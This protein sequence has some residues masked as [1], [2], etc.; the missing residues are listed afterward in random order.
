MATSL[1]DVKIQFVA[2]GV[3]NVLSAI[4]TLET[5]F[6]QL[7]N[8]MT[9]LAKKGAE[10]RTNAYR[11][12]FDVKKSLAE[13]FASDYNTILQKEVAHHHS[14]INRKEEQ[15]R[16]YTQVLRNEAA[17]RGQIFSAALQSMGIQGVNAHS[18]I[19]GQ[20]VPHG[21][22]S[23]MVGSAALLAGSAAFFGQGSI[24]RSRAGIYPLKDAFPAGMDMPEGLSRA[25]QEAFKIRHRSFGNIAKIGYHNFIAKPA[26]SVQDFLSSNPEASSPLSNMDRV[27]FSA[28]RAATGGWGRV[29]QQ[30]S[31][32]G[33]AVGSVMTAPI[34]GPVIAGVTAAL[35]AFKQ[36]LDVVTGA[37]KQAASEM[38]A[39]VM[40]I[41]GGFS[42]SGSLV[43]SASLQSM[44]TRISVNAATPAERMPTAEILDWAMSSSRTGEHSAEQYMSGMSTYQALT[45]RNK[46]FKNM[47][48]FIGKMATVSGSSF[49]E[50]AKSMGQTRLQFGEFSPQQMQ[51]LMLKQWQ[52]G[53]EGSIEIGNAG[54]MARVTAGARQLAG[55]PT[56]ENFMT[57]IGAVQ[58]ARRSVA[59]PEEAVTAYERFQSFAAANS[60]KIVAAGGHAV[61]TQTPEGEKF[62]DMAQTMVDAAK[63]LKQPGGFAKATSLYGREGIR[64]AQ[65][66]SN[67]IG[68][69][70][71]DEQALK[72]IRDL[73]KV[74]ASAEDLD[75]AFVEMQG[76]VQY[77]LKQAFNEL[78]MEVGEGLLGVLKENMP[79]IKGMLKDLIKSLP[80][81]MQ[82]FM[83]LLNILPIVGEV[84]FALTPA[85][86]AASK[87]MLEIAQ[88]MG[89]VSPGQA[90]ESNRNLD[91]LG[92]K[93]VESM[94]R[95]RLSPEEKS[96]EAKQDLEAANKVFRTYGISP[97]AGKQLLNNPN[98]NRIF[99]DMLES[100]AV[101]GGKKFEKP[102]VTK[103]AGL[104]AALQRLSVI[105]TGGDALIEAANRLS[106]AASDLSG[107]GSGG[108][109]I[110]IPEVN[111]G[112]AGSNR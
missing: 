18:Q 102:D 112:P 42:I 58:I 19:S 105:Q 1:P 30:I 84:F 75:K 76:T 6:T 57:Q 95:S 15:E 33:S 4:K 32:V 56:V 64:M 51:E 29:G 103:D 43:K 54:Q 31:S 91:V 73:L 69:G 3:S 78:T 49:E 70:K 83:S 94:R 59:S 20:L 85:V 81:L 11:K 17:K 80:A 41:G 5:A 9:T 71:T 62:K 24:S 96:T 8:K 45:G 40:Q 61:M 2:G 26:S 47:S 48:G 100:G 110:T 107:S 89:T 35:F 99:Y 12:E 55:G 53:K 86:I 92:A 72:I 44:A 10:D 27:R 50:M 97:E 37:L 98:R 16:R 22:G 34:S 60:A 13:K 93:L 111:I 87:V 66:V 21:D 82:E 25:E 104:V 63:I 23:G 39:G 14:A 106:N 74:S 108:G 28:L 65:A 101:V 36:G 79:Q 88:F 7:E 52:A 67:V 90:W 38:V 109:V 46:E 68:E 77:Q